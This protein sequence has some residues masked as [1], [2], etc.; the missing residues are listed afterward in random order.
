MHTPAC[1]TVSRTTA[2]AG[3]TETDCSSSPKGSAALQNYIRISLIAAIAFSLFGYIASV[4]SQ[5]MKGPSGPLMAAAF[6]FTLTAMD[7]ILIQRNFNLKQVNAV[8]TAAIIPFYFFSIS[9]PLFRSCPSVLSPLIALSAFSLITLI[10]FSL[11]IYL[12]KQ[13]LIKIVR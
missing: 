6:L 12:M 5:G 13:V 8:N 2:L 9:L 7:F 11:I 3:M 1:R 10:S 4:L